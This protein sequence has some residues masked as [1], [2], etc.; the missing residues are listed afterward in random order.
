MNTQR[1]RS[2]LIWICTDNASGSR[3]VG[4]ADVFDKTTIAALADRFAAFLAERVASPDAPAV[5]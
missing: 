3:L 4:A 2:D 1:R 5:E